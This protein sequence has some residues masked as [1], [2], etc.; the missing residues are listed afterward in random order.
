M[1][2]L[3]PQGP[4]A[5][6]EKHLLFFA[7]GLMLIIVVPTIL[8]SWIIAYKYRASNKNAK[9]DPEWSHNNLLEAAW[10]VAPIIIIV[11]LATITWI[12]AHKLD[13]YRPLDSK[14]K[15]ITIQVVALEWKWLFIYPE[16][17][18]ATVNYV[19]F[20]A[21]TPVNFLITADAPM[22]SF[23]IPALGGQIYAMDGMQTKL[24]LLADNVGQY[25][26]RS[27]SFSGDGFTG[28]EFTAKSLTSEDFN[29]W[30]KSVKKSA[31]NKLTM[32]TYNQL[33]KPSE[34]TPV[35]YYSSVSNNLF[36]D[37]MM[38]Y[39]MPPMPNNSQHINNAVTTNVVDSVKNN[40]TIEKM[41]NVKQLDQ[42]K[43][44]HRAVS[45]A[46]QS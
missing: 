20:P 33:A 16:Q 10:W 14:V 39:M 38:K 22:N 13:P 4:I 25:N 36:N 7:V 30:V 19:A 6:D 40:K 11:I 32:D 26:G 2:I 8:L 3:N 46:V 24:H 23:Q 18:I 44:K 34:N 9:Y 31:K 15:P 12:T 28:M 21:Q 45:A 17:G 41:N 1:V 43:P 27:V 35:G 29:K 37:I 42:P 5:S